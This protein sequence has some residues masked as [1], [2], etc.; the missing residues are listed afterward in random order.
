MPPLN[1]LLVVYAFPPATGVGTLRAA[2]LARHLPAEGIRLDVLTTRNPSSAGTDMGLLQEIPPEVTIHRTVTLDLP[3]GVK[4]L[5]K[6]ALTRTNPQAAKTASSAPARKTG[7]LKRVIQN[8]LM[9]DPQVLWLP[10]L[11]PVA[12]RIVRKRKIH[13]V[14]ITGAP[15]S[16]HL[17]AERLR[18]SFPKLKIVLDFR[19]EWITAGFDEASFVFNTSERARA[20]A[21]RAEANAV[22]SADAVV[23]VTGVARKEIRSRYPSDPDSKFHLISNGFDGT[24]IRPSAPGN[25]WNPER[26][27]A[28]TYTGTIYSTYTNPASL[29]EAIQSLPAEIKSR[30]VFRFVGHIEESRVREALLKL[31]DTVELTGYLPQVKAIELMNASDYALL[32]SHD[33]LNVSG[34]FYEYVG[35]HKPVLACVPPACDVRYMIEDLRAGWW[36]DSRDPSAIRQLLID[37]ANRADTL[38]QE[39]HPNL[40]KIAQYERKPLAQRYAALLHSLAAH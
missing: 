21:V 39:F 14:I 34:K 18:K 5:L 32:I 35:A 36:A 22:A 28:V 27:I 6:R 19:D 4:K 11:T 13:A 40:D 17:L 12:R 26:K 24:R 25:C 16:T 3:F 23:M 37:A 15:F 10:V 2:S 38:D 33:R 1:V 9:P 8:A 20:F 30:F 29:I 7:L 31:G